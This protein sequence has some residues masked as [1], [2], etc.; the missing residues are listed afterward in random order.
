[1]TLTTALLIQTAIYLTD[2]PNMRQLPTGEA[3]MINEK[4]WD[5][6]TVE[7]IRDDRW[8]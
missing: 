4:I 3:V 5:N 6:K 7:R 2:C 1:M 8:S